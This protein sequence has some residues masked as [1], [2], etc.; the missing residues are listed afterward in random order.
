MKATGGV[1]AALISGLLLAASGPAGA[2]PAA[3]ADD[4]VHGAGSFT[5][6]P[7]QFNFFRVAII[8][9]SGPNGESPA[10]RMK[11]VARDEPPTLARVRCLRVIGT[12]ALVTGDRG[13]H[14]R[15][16]LDGMGFY[17]EDRTSQDLPDRIAVFFF[18]H[19]R[20]WIVIEDGKVFLGGDAN[21]N[22]LGFE[23]RAK[24]VMALIREPRNA[25]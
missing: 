4:S 24:K 5:E 3:G 1:S 17:I 18:S 14:L 8:A 7:R 9:T 19:Q 25:S 21:R 15:G 16:G 10:G 13:P 2:V 6:S 11:F 22:R 20:L 12:N 23:D